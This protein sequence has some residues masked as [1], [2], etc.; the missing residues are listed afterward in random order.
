MRKMAFAKY[1]AAKS[2]NAGC[3]LFPSD[4]VV[5]SL[6]HF[7]TL[8][9]YPSGDE[10]RQIP[11]AILALSIHSLPNRRHRPN[12]WNLS[13]LFAT[14]LYLRLRRLIAFALTHSLTVGASVL[15]PCFFRCCGDDEPF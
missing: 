15:I 12:I 6:F 2:V 11:V 9:L 7:Y 4:W 1:I 13:P 5:P 10:V 8:C 14:I 3:R